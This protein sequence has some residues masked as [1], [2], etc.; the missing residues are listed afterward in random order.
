MGLQHIGLIYKKYSN[1]KMEKGKW[2]LSDI[3]IV[4]TCIILLLVYDF[5]FLFLFG[6]NGGLLRRDACSRYPLQ[7][8][9]SQIH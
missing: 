6:A 9:A 2:W 1:K 8:Q 7:S 3:P 5:V 4:G